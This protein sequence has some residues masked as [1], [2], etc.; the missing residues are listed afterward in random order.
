MKGDSLWKRL[1]DLL[2]PSISY[3]RPAPFAKVLTSSAKRYQREAVTKLL[4]EGRAARAWDDGTVHA[5][6]AFLAAR[7]EQVIRQLDDQEAERCKQGGL[8]VARLASEI[9]RRDV[10]LEALEAE[11]RRLD[12]LV[13]RAESVL[14]GG[15]RLAREVPTPHVPM[16]ARHF[17]R[18]DRFG[19]RGSG[20][21]RWVTATENGSIPIIRGQQ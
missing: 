18:F 20:D 3:W 2:T 21:A 8:F 6:D 19:L 5:L 1:R 15:D 11:L 16:Q 17:D 7:K 9:E 12:E 14:L 13:D 4:E 10:R